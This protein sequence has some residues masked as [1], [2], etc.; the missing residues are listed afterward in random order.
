MKINHIGL[1]GQVIARRM[2]REM[3]SPVGPVPVIGSPLQLSGSPARFDGIPK[4][5]EDTEAIL[6]ELGYDEQEIEKLHQ[7]R[8]IYGPFDG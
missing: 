6:K 5:G 7:D 3:A 4:L 1:S 2:V 8:V